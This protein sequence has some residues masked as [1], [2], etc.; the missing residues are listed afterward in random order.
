MSKVL[1]RRDEFG[2]VLY[3]SATVASET[4][5]GA[6]LARVALLW[7]LVDRARRGR[8]DANTSGVDKVT[9]VYDPSVPGEALR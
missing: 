7:V 2:E 9:E 4:E 3:G 5:E 1:K 8:V 6:N